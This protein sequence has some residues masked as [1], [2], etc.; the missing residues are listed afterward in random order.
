LKLFAHLSVSPRDAIV[1][2][3]LAEVKAADEIYSQTNEELAE[4][5]ELDSAVQSQKA[6]EIKSALEPMHSSIDPIRTLKP[7]V[8]A[9]DPGCS[10]HM[11]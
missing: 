6:T 1:F 8:S 4:A 2:V 10:I 5:I 11:N 9:P 7:Y 3:E